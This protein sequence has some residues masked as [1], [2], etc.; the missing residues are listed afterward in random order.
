MASRAGLCLSLFALVLVQASLAQ[1]L[2]QTPLNRE[3]YH[4]GVHP[5][6]GQEKP[7]VFRSCPQWKTLGACVADEGGAAEC[8]VFM[9]EKRG[10]RASG[11]PPPQ[12]RWTKPAFRPRRPSSNVIRPI[13]MRAI[14][15]TYCTY[16]TY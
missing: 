2:C 10:G 7:I 8:V 12:Q 6:C 9:R 11:P 16:R 3:Y 13:P 5:G 1:S 14:P 15:I 4:P